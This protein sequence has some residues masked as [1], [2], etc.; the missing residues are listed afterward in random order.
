MDRH[1]DA[2]SRRGSPDP[3]PEEVALWLENLPRIRPGHEQ[4]FL[5]ITRAVR[6]TADFAT[7][8]RAITAALG[9]PA[10]IG[11]SRFILLIDRA[12]N[13]WISGDGPGLVDALAQADLVLKSGIDENAGGLP[14]MVAY[15]NFLAALLRYRIAN[16]ELYRAV[17]EEVC[18]IGDSHSLSYA[19]L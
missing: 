3:T 12:T 19:N 4:A 8:D 13:R 15:A 7:W 18:V 5:D 16:P 10:L 1:T 11:A 6:W 14:G 2:W 17:G 9:N